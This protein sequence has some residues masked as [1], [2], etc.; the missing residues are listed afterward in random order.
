M[1]K[2]LVFFG[3]CFIQM[4]NVADYPR[5]SFQ[6]AP[7]PS[8]IKCHAVEVPVR[9]ADLLLRTTKT[10]LPTLVI[11]PIAKQIF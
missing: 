1:I 5:K 10:K 8:L 6:S 3:S 9:K 7:T 4:P 2:H 11:A